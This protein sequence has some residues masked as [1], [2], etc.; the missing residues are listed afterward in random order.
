MKKLGFAA[1]TALVALSA[2]AKSPSSIPPVAVASSEYDGLSCQR[3]M[4]EKN[5]V[6]IKLNAANKKQNQAQ[7]ADAI[8]V[9]LVLIPV[10]KLVGD[11][12]GEIGQLKGEHLALERSLERRN[13]V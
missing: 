3:L 6:A 13:C 8:G 10:S 2:C 7:T 9:F 12:E 11:A 4:S 1:L 5:E